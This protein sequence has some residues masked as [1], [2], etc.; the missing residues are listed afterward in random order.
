MPAW[1][2]KPLSDPARVRRVRRTLERCHLTTVCDEA[3]CPNRVDCFTRGTATFMVLGDSCTRDCRFCAV[4]HAAPRSVDPG[5]PARVAEAART[6]GLEF[7]VVTSVTRDDLQ[8]GGAGHFAATVHAVREALPEAGVEVLVPDFQGRRPS[9]ETV[10]TSRPDVFGHNV[11]T[12]R[13]LYG[14]ARPEA[15][16][17]RTLSVLE[18]ASRNAH[19]GPARTAVKSAMMLGL[20]ETRSEVEE[21]LLDLRNAGVEIVCLGQYLSPSDD[22][23]PVARFVPPDEFAELEVVARSM[24]FAAVAAGPF[25]RS[26]YLAEEFAAQA[27]E[28]AAETM[29]A[30]RKEHS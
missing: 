26:S 13:R 12:V 19:D 22:H 3:R 15:D 20:G 29:S 14:A 7:V 30:R 25:V 8:D 21:T 16:Y 9:I 4:N 11:E 10:L 1:L 5:E 28:A 17:D 23:L 24:G 2:T 6:L 27:R 18:F